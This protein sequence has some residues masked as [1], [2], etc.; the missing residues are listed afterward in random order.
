[1]S[2]I[3]LEP[4]GPADLPALAALVA[5]TP[6]LRRYGRTPEGALAALTAALA[7]GDL[8]LVARAGRR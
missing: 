6:L 5:G 3:V 8:L 4:A 7:A 2:R 1:M